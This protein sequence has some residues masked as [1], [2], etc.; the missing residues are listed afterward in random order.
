ME[1]FVLGR[2]RIGIAVIR[3]DP[4]L[5]AEIMEKIV[6]RALQEG[7]ITTAAVAIGAFKTAVECALDEQARTAFE[8]AVEA[9]A[10]RIASA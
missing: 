4:A 1:K 8:K 9:S 6:R 3:H 5:A 10:G 2:I 7:E